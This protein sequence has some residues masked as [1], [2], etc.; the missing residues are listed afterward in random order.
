MAVEMIFLCSFIATKI[1]CILHT[2]LNW[3]LMSFDTIQFF[4]F[5]F[6]WITWIFD[7][8]EKR[9]PLY[10]VLERVA[11][12]IWCTRACT[13]IYYMSY[14]IHHVMDTPIHYIIDGAKM[15][16]IYKNRIILHQKYSSQNTTCPT[17]YVPCPSCNVPHPSYYVPCLSYDGYL[18]SY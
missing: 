7:P 9:Y 6:T 8:L 1:T 11:S 12:I 3:H 10:D 13:C 4:N 2:L 18:F 14:P 15:P 17:Y 16:S 5:V